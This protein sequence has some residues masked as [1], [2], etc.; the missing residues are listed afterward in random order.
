MRCDLPHPAC[1]LRRITSGGSV[2]VTPRTWIRIARNMGIGQS[3]DRDTPADLTQQSLRLAL[4]RGLRRSRL[5]RCRTGSGGVSSSETTLQRKINAV[6][7]GPTELAKRQ[8]NPGPAET[9][10]DAYLF[11][12]V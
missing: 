6:Q 5:R 2:K 9:A 7:T 10:T 3:Y 1:D 4:W 11:C 12:A 8:F